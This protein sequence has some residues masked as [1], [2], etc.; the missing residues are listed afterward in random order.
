MKLKLRQVQDSSEVAKLKAELLHLRLENEKL[1]V[2]L[3][4][5][6]LTGL[7]NARYLRT[8]LE[9]CV[10]ELILKNRKPALLFIDVDYFKEVNERHGHLAAGKVLE[11]IGRLIARVVRKGD[12]AFRY[13]GDE[14]VVLV[15]GGQKGA[16][17]V[18]E[19]IRQAIAATS[20]AVNGLCGEADVGVTVSVGTCVIKPG[21]TVS[22]VLESADRAMFEAKRN[23][24]NT[25]VAA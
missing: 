24:R 8:R 12:I 1:K 5:D 23:S 16:L 13:G 20:Y 14:F 25:L 10:S 3:N 11:Q 7:F 17:Q 15:S 21:D 22:S 2:E 19:R 6:D 18:G 9:E 4:S